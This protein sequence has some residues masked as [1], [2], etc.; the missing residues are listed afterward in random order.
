MIQMIFSAWFGMVIENRLKI[1]KA[2]AV[3]DWKISVKV[4]NSW[5]KYSIQEN[6][7][8]QQEQYKNELKTEH[9]KMK[10][11]MNFHKLNLL[12]KYIDRWKQ[13]IVFSFSKK[14]LEQEKFKTRNRMENFLKAA[15]QGNLWDK[16]SN[17]TDNEDFDIKNISPIKGIIMNI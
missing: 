11:A 9:N 6:Y 4:F 1:S 16:E 8:K 2:N 17:V 10:R 13:Y 3:N 15:S 12:K 7:K 5:K 14:E